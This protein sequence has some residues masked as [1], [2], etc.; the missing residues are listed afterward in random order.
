M[1]LTGSKWFSRSICAAFFLGKAVMA[2]QDFVTESKDVVKVHF[3]PH[4]HMDAGWRQTFE[5][6]YNWRVRKIF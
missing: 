5:G 2:Q 6:Y 3:V 1:M 4:S